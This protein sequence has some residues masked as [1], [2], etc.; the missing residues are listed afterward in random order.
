MFNYY[1]FIKSKY[2]TVTEVLAEQAKQ[3]NLSIRVIDKFDG[4]DNDKNRITIVVMHDVIID[5]Y[6][7]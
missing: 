4:D 1:R 5:I 3:D 6:K 2:S 7:G